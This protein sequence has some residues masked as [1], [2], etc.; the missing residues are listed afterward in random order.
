MT[1]SYSEQKHQLRLKQRQA[2]LVSARAQLDE[3]RENLLLIQERE[4][5]FVERTT[6]PLQLLKTKQQTQ[7]LISDL[8]LRVS[9]LE[10]EISELEAPLIRRRRFWQRA[11][12]AAAGLG[13]VALL[14]L[15]AV[16]RSQIVPLP[17]GF[18]VG[19]AQFVEIDPDGRALVTQVSRDI[20]DR[21]ARSLLI[22]PADGSEL[23]NFLAPADLGPVIGA[24][25]EERDRRAAAL[26]GQHNVT[27]LISG[28]VTPTGDGNYQVEPNFYL[29]DTGSAYGAEIRGPSRL[30]EAVSYRPAS[31]P[32]VEPENLNAELTGR[33]KVLASVMHGLRDLYYK[34]FD[35]ADAEFGQALID[36]SGQRGREVI[37]L[38]R[39]AT[40][41][42]R[43]DPLFLDEQS[44]E[45]LAKAYEDFANAMSENGDYARGYLG[46]GAVALQQALR[47]A[48]PYADKLQEA[49]TWYQ[50]SRQASDK[51]A[52]AYVDDKAAF[53]VGQTYLAGYAL[54]W[55]PAVAELELT[56]VISD[57]QARPTVTELQ[58]LAGDSEC[59]LGWLAGHRY[60][61]WQTLSARCQAG[62]KLLNR[63]PDPPK[64][65]IALYWS[66]VA[67]ADEQRGDLTAARANYERAILQREQLFGPEQADR[68]DNDVD[69]QAWRA[70]FNRLAV[71]STPTPAGGS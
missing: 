45:H 3:E 28:V 11:A 12:L 42:R 58:R 55:S 66:W 9:V 71:P 31:D 30:G 2:E 54:G 57:Y 18:N 65:W 10:K 48:P 34:K 68:R 13:V 49:F 60:E 14:L 20:S 35:R 69:L 59:L 67:A 7:A 70:A 41:L 26:A 16:L 43:Y 22:V 29:N 61:D 38:L 63:L 46:L 23:D 62:I 36:W 4:S 47:A 37:Y 5:Q 8:E 52:A 32:A 56:R 17:R 53:G 1:S 44:V 24:T 27:M 19:V 51:P 33:F 50:K 40:W 39:G 15:I 25:T 21:L 6:I 64:A